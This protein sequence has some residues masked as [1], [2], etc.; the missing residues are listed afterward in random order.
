MVEPVA[1]SI[2]A[3]WNIAFL[4]LIL[5]RAFVRIIDQVQRS[6]AE[7]NAVAAVLMNRSALFVLVFAVEIF[8][9]DQPMAGGSDA[10]FGHDG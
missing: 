2:T 1:G 9:K 4:Q 10:G 3:G 5:E 7:L 8:G 6:Q